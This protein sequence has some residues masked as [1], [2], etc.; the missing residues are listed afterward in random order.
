MSKRERWERET[1][2]A[3]IVQASEHHCRHNH[4]QI[5]SMLADVILMLIR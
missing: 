4:R 2:I 1:E 5:S 3:P